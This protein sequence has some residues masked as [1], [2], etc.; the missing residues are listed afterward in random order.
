Q[1]ATQAP[2][3]V[4]RSAATCGTGT[5]RVGGNMIAASPQASRQLEQ[6]MPRAARQVSPTWARSVQESPV[7]GPKA[8][9]VHAVAQSPQNVHSPRAGSNSG[10]RPPAGTSTCSGHAAT[11]SPQPVQASTKRDSSSAHGGRSGGGACSRPR[12]SALRPRSGG[13]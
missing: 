9:R 12:S 10:S 3:P 4:Q 8:E 2:Q 13:L 11:Q 5:V 1:P 7:T 6:T